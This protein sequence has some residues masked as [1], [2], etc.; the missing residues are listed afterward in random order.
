MALN[1]TGY[2]PTTGRSKP[3][4]AR[5]PGATA[6]SSRGENKKLAKV[7]S[8]LMSN[9]SNRH[10]FKRSFMQMSKDG[11][12]LEHMKAPSPS[13]QPCAPWC[14]RV[15]DTRVRLPPSFCREER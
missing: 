11:R 2:A 6:N 5:P 4:M 10:M 8:K 15:A 3:R 14:K 1:N 12:N 9:M 13:R 7:A